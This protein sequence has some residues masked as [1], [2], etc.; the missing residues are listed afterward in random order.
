[1]KALILFLV[2]YLVI[3]GIAFEL[4]RTGHYFIGATLAILLL[5]G[6]KLEHKKSDG[7]D[8]MEAKPTR[9]KRLKD[10]LDQEG[11]S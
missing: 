4:V 2:I 11:K 6:T 9:L 5:C 7:W 8:E 3:G 10:I 1:M